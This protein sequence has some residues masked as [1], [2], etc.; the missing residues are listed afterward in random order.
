VDTPATRQQ[1]HVVMAFRFLAAIACAFSLVFAPA[2]LSAQAMRPLAEAP[3]QTKVQ[4]IVVF[5]FFADQ[6]GEDSDEGA[7]AAARAE[8]WAFAAVAQKPD[9]EEEI[10]ADVDAEASKFQA[11]LS[12]AFASGGEAAV[13]EIVMRYLGAC[14][15][16]GG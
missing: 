2:G 16:F 12:S 14:D 4:C 6:F 9:R 5:T 1:E 10:I 13:G 3:Y 11:A 8:E 15:Q 7:E